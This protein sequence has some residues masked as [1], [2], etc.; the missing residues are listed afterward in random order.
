MRRSGK[1]YRLLQEMDALLQQG[2]SPSR[3][4]YFN[5][6]DE[7][8]APVT[9]ATGDEVLETFFAA[10]PEAF[11]DGVF[12]FLDEIQE[13]TN[14][15][16]WLRRIVDTTKATIY[17]SGSSSKMLSSEIATEFRG[18]AI[19]FELLPYSFR[20]YVRATEL[21]DETNRSSWSMRDR[22]ELQNALKRFLESGGFP[23]ACS[24]SRPQAIMLLQ[25]YAERVVSR[26]VVERHDIARH[27]VASALAR[28]VLGSNA[29]NLSLR[30][31]EADLRSLGIR[32]SRATLAEILDYMEEAYLVFRVNRFSYALSE[33]TTATPKIYAIDQG[34]ALANA[35]ANSNDL[36]QRLE[37]AVYL[38]LRRRRQGQRRETVCSYQT[39]AH[40]YEIDFVVGDVLEQEPYQFV[41]VCAD[42][43]D[44]TTLDRELC[45]LWEGMAEADMLDSVLVTLEG[46]EQVYEHQGMRVRQMPAWRWLLGG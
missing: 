34:L 5:F 10:N 43:S 17:A 7:R 13:M 35:K 6:E 19:D 20:E 46:G 4:C 3:I 14:W 8:L 22:I 28:R 31:V 44:E 29:R 16:A 40:S 21:L 38:E 9:P 27:G 42:A 45:A 41:Q 37:N 2:V 23:A 12:L 18:R 11:D 24:L 32:T 33:R 36:G 15:G 25:S 30:N 1:S 39:R 26:D